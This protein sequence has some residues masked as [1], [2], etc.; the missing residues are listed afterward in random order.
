MCRPLERVTT[1]SKYC[2]AD[3]AFYLR[4]LNNPQRGLISRYPLV[5]CKTCLLVLNSTLTDN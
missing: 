4:G 5:L 2:K 3:L 1:K